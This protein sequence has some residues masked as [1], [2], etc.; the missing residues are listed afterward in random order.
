MRVCSFC[1]TVKKLKQLKSSPAVLQQLCRRC[2]DDFRR[3]FKLLLIEEVDFPSEM[4]LKVLE[5]NI[6]YI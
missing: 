3:R 4:S 1:Y 5:V 6:T 2:I